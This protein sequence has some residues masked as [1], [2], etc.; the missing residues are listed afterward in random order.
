MK[1]EKFQ[2]NLL[3]PYL[4]NTYFNLQLK[5]LLCSSINIVLFICIQIHTGSS[6][7]SIILTRI[8]T[9]TTNIVISGI[10]VWIEINII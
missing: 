9:L 6:Y 10:S 2:A 7:G 5:T 4:I 3:K 1:T 8:I